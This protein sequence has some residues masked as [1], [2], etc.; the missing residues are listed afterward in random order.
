MAH[1]L[2]KDELPQSKTTIRERKVA[3]S[4]NESGIV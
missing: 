4:V 2:V 1:H 3:A